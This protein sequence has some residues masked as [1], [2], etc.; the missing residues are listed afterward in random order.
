MKG[1]EF[2]SVID[3]RRQVE[4]RFGFFR[5]MM[6]AKNRN[7][8]RDSHIKNDSVIKAYI[9]KSVIEARKQV[10]EKFKFFRE[11]MEVKNCNNSRN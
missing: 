11:M 9:F 7:Q 10:D 6:A 4:E 8:N 2:K 3:A 5:E 1:Y